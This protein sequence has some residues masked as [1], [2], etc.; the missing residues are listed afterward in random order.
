[1]KKILALAVLGI[2]FCYT[3]ARASTDVNLVISTAAWSG[4]NVTTGTVVRVDNFKFGTR[5][6]VDS[7]RI[8]IEVQNLDSADS[9]FCGYDASV[10]TTTA[11]VLQANSIGKEIKSGDVVYIGLLRQASYH[12]RAVDA[13]GSAGVWIH[14][15]QLHKE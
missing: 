14:L 7:T 1:M 15:E 5:P 6:T 9:I 8:G 4:V 11:T 10:T 2:A 3:E 13:A 12:C